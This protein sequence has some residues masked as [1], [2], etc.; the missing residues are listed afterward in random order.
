MF[1]EEK[2]IAIRRKWEEKVDS[3]VVEGQQKKVYA[4]LRLCSCGHDRM[5]KICMS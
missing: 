1:F 5:T 4:N 2:E 3:G